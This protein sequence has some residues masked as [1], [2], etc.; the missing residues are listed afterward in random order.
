[1]QCW[2]SFFF[3]CH[4]VMNSHKRHIGTFLTVIQRLVW[5]YPEIKSSKIQNAK[6]AKDLVS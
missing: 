2:D 1:M 5:Q 4:I 6:L 3:I